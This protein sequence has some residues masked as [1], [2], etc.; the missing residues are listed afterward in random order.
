MAF[1][2]SPQLL[3]SAVYAVVTSLGLEAK[4]QRYVAILLTRKSGR[5]IW[6]T[7]VN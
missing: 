5:H 2:G 3:F 1:N 6:R 7:D 4:N